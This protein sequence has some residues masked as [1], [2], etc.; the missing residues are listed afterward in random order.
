MKS[1]KMEIGPIECLYIKIEN[2]LVEMQKGNV[3]FMPCL[4]PTGEK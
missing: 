3:E 2:L 1:E 4:N